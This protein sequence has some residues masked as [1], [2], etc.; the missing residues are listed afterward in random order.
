MNGARQGPEGLWG[1]RPAP[2]KG[3]TQ[4]LDVGPLTVWLRGGES[5]LWVASHRVPDGDP[6]WDGELPES[7]EWSRWALH[8][9]QRHLRVTPV[10]PDRPLV[11][12][13]DHSFTLMRRAKARIYMRVPA[14]V[15]IETMS[16]PGGAATLLTEIPTVQL[17]D[18][19][20]GDFLDG[21]L[22][23]WL[24]TRGRREI[25]PDLFQP[26]LVMCTLQMDNVSRDDLHVEK[27]SLRVG[28]LS[29][30]RKDGWLWAEEVRVEY[31]GED[32]G[33][34]IHMDDRPPA[35]AAGAVEISPAR[36]QAR[37]F[38]TRTFARLKALTAWGG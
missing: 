23:F 16:A 28:H 8:G 33:S 17:S 24:T 13:P 15:R 21:E 38:R 34:E 19:W 29:I 4:R 6:H 14:W 5:E 35:E 36:H 30:Y 3:E 31:H 27:L 7:A 11:V 22:A 12:K 1:S 9:D 18:T 10:F 20:W 2:A 26:H 25:T 37:S 32:E